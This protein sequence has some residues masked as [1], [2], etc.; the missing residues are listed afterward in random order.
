MLHAG[1]RDL[2]MPRVGK[3]ASSL[4]SLLTLGRAFSSS[5]VSAGR[6]RA[7]LERAGAE[8]ADDADIEGGPLRP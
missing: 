8:A 1:S 3:G 5:G 7:V 6:E 2:N 4:V